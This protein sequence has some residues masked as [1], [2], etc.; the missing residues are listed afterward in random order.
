MMISLIILSL[1]L[2]G[3]VI[4]SMVMGVGMIQDEE[5]VPGSCCILMSFVG[6]AG[7]FGMWGL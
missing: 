7:M 1:V 3:F 5:V 6:I 4:I 2:L